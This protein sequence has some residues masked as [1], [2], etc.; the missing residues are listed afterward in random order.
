MIQLPV[1]FKPLSNEE[2]L[3]VAPSVFATKPWE[4]VSKR[5]AFIPTAHVVDALRDSGFQ[6]V[7]ASQSRVRV[8]GKKPYTKH[9]LRFRHKDDLR[10]KMKMGDELVE[11]VLTNAHDRSSAYCLDA[12]I[13]KMICSN[14]MIISS[15]DF[16]SIHIYHSGDVV[17]EVLAAT[18]DIVTRAPTIRE[19]VA[20]WRA[21]A[22]SEKHQRILAEAALIARYGL[23]DFNNLLSPISVEAVL[24][25]RRPEDQKPDLWTVTNVVQENLMKGEIQGRSASGRRVSTRPIKSINA[26]LDLN[27]AVWS[28]ASE[29]EER[30]GRKS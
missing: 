3:A 20:R 27:R 19:Q 9:M 5:Y 6:P 30:L 24:M 12:G 23:D 13:F 16:G 10:T 14:G 2:I 7:R 18:K 28:I 11:V 22:L 21:I 4:G 25:P 17:D 29:M 8:A 1:P 15:A 26:E